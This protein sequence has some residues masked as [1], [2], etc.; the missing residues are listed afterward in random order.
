MKRQGLLLSLAIM[1]FA[2]PAAVSAK[3]LADILPQ[4]GTAVLTMNAPDVIWAN[5]KTSN[6]MPA[7]TREKLEQSWTKMWQ[8]TW[9]KQLR[10]MFGMQPLDLI[11]KDASRLGV[12]FGN[13]DSLAALLAKDEEPKPEDLPMAFFL[14]SKDKAAF[15]ASL[16]AFVTKLIELARKEGEEITRDQDEF[17]DIPFHV[18]H[19]EKAKGDAPKHIYYAWSGNWVFMT[20]SRPY[21]E[22]ILSVSEGAPPLAKQE[23]YMAAMEALGTGNSEMAGYI[24]LSPIFNMIKKAAQQSMASTAAPG[25]PQFEKSKQQMH[26]TMDILDLLF[27]ELK[28]ISFK[29]GYIPGGAVTQFLVTC[30]PEKPKGLLHILGKK[31]NLSFP[32]WLW[33]DLS[34]KTTMALDSALLSDLIGKVLTTIFSVQMGPDQ[35]EMWKMQFSMFMGMDLQKDL[36]GSLS[37]QAVIAQN[38]KQGAAVKKES[39][40]L[41]LS[42]PAGEALFAFVLDRDEPWKKLLQQVMMLSQGNFKQEDYMGTPL[43]SLKMGL[44]GLNIMSGVANKAFLLG[45]QDMVEK[46]VRRMGKEDSATSSVDPAFKDALA[47]AGKPNAALSW[48]SSSF[49]DSLEFQAAKGALQELSSNLSEVDDPVVKE[50]GQSLIQL[51]EI[52][53]DPANWKG[54]KINSLSTGN[55]ESQGLRLKNVE[56]FT[57]DKTAE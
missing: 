32:D 1:L 28:N 29:N 56:Y 34:M 51:V 39:D 6:V 3:D 57:E 14:A 10:E 53:V 8:G 21:L 31:D 17:H 9:E 7:A 12:T 24:K 35:A 16:D 5:F 50:L 2:A 36:L 18:L 49:E 55:W 41:D 27:S 11:L 38:V 30:D 40:S 15:Q 44:P 26:A 45:T 33:S 19:N 54:M 46:T 47:R 52:L 48:S 13:L 37:D 25:T 43:Y 20:F 4:D 42:S 23:E 22:K